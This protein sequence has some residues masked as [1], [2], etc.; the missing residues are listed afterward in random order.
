MR[1]FR[2]RGRLGRRLGRRVFVLPFPCDGSIVR[3]R[4]GHAPRHRQRTR[5][6]RLSRVSVIVS[7]CSAAPTMQDGSL[8]PGMR[9]SIFL[10]RTTHQPSSI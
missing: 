3:Y 1:F 9:G 7:S 6:E 2:A 10:H 5:R 4:G 8:R